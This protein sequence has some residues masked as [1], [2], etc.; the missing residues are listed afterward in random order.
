[1]A[2]MFPSDAKRSAVYFGISFSKATT[3]AT[4]E[5]KGRIVAAKKAEKNKASSE[6]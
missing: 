5:L 1:M 3:S 6:I 4:S 2:E